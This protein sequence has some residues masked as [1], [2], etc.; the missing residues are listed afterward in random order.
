MWLVGHTSSP[1]TD[2]FP[3]LSSHTANTH[4]RRLL[5]SGTFLLFSLAWEQGQSFFCEVSFLMASV[6]GMG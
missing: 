6:G 4:H 1:L 2:K 3:S 5:Q